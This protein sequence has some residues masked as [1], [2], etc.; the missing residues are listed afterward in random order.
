L[1]T[2][3][4]G[5]SLFSIKPFE[6]FRHTFIPEISLEGG[7]KI[8][9]NGKESLD[10][11]NDERR[12]LFSFSNIFEGKNLNEK[13]LLLR[14]NINLYYNLKTDS[15]SNISISNGLLPEKR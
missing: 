3:I 15:F 9:F 11:L 1:N 7:N 2:Q 12:L 5:I 10:S 6:K 14:N 8:F 13:I 4:Y